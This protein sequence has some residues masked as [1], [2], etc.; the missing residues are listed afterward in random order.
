MVT[1]KGFTL[2]EMLITIALIVILVPTMMQASMVFTRRQPVHTRTGFEQMETR[3][4][5]QHLQKNMLIARE[6][7]INDEKIIVRTFEDEA[8][9]YRLSEEGV[10]VIEKNGQ[11]IYRV[12][13]IETF[14]INEEELYEISIH[15]TE[16]PDL[17]RRSGSY[18]LSLPAGGKR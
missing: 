17:G 10:L 4:F 5:L 9:T 13:G 1:G 18:T 2:I 7:E 11:E 12:E 15:T 16:V 3:F 8:F 14:E 6:V